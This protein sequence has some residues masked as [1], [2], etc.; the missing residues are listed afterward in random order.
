MT[1]IVDIAGSDALLAGR[2][3]L[4][5]RD[6]GACKVRLERCHTGVDQQYRIIIV[7]YQRE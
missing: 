4:P 3:P 5:R 6:L 7:G 1:D 2:D